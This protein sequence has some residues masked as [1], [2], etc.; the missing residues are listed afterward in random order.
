[1]PEIKANFLLVKNLRHR[2]VIKYEA[3]YID[4][5]KHAC[6]LVMEY[7]AA[8]PLN[9]GVVGSEGQLRGVA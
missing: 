8:R 5:K 1:L 3:L 6:W 9:A 4:I 2:C 7:I